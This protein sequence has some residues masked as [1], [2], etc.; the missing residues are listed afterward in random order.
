LILPNILDAFG[1]AYGPIRVVLRMSEAAK[2][3]HPVPEDRDSRPIEHIG[4]E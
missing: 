2:P 3:A 4:P 1:S